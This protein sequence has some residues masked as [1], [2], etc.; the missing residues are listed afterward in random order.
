MQ[1]LAVTRTGQ[2]AEQRSRRQAFKYQNHSATYTP[3]IYT[4]HLQINHSH[5]GGF[6]YVCACD[7][8][9]VFT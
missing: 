7:I 3:V 9:R 6:S 1:V 8:I 5:D 4:H 2:L